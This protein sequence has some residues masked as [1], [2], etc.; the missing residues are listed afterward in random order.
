VINSA[1]ESPAAGSDPSFAGGRKL[2]EVQQAQLWVRINEEPAQP[3]SHVVRHLAEA[4]SPV[5]CG[6]RHLNRLRV[7]WG[8]NRGKGRP[9]RPAKPARRV[10]S[11][12]ALVE[13]APHVS[14]AGVHLFA[15]WMESGDK[16][17]MV[18]ALLMERIEEYRHIH[19][20]AEF[21]LLHHKPETL[22]R[23]F[24][25]LFYAPLL[26]ADGRRSERTI[27]GIL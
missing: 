8:L 26:W 20:E 12:E 6:I 24:H 27:P 5:S 19:P 7:A 25:A 3:S 18:V 14:F 4:G 17:G 15:A 23:R 13:L 1:Q 10:G 21:A 2:T 11:R 22:E 16:F 9:R